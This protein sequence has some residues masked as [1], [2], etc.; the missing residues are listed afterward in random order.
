MFL[1]PGT[2]TTI[3]GLPIEGLIPKTPHY[4][5]YSG[6]LTQPG[7]RETV[8]WVIYNKPLSISEDQV[9]SVDSVSVLFVHKSVF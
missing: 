7:C 4:M 6:S 8:T 3:E 5:T 2:C 9:I 1:F